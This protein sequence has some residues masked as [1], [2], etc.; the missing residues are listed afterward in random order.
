MVLLPS[1]LVLSFI[2]HKGRTELRDWQLAD[3]LGNHL[4]EIYLKKV[5]EDR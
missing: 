3:K 2:P 4:A 1:C 5:K